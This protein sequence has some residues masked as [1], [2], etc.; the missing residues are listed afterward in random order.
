MKDVAFESNIVASD[1]W[2][3]VFEERGAV[4]LPVTGSRDG[5]AIWNL[6]VGKY[7]TSSR[8]S[9]DFA[10]YLSFTWGSISTTGGISLYAGMS[11]RLVQDYQQ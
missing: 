11:V 7:W 1:I 5:V 9:G 6:W 2:N 4:F 8:H 3:T 10:R